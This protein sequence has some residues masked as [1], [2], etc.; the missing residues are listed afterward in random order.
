M[1]FG[2]DLGLTIS[3]EQLEA[4][5]HHHGIVEGMHQESGR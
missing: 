4:T 2:R 1:K 5:L 3:G